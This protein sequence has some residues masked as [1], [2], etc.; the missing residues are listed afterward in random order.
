MDD[1]EL[2]I[3]NTAAA[4]TLLDSLGTMPNDQARRDAVSE[5]RRIYN[6]MAFALVRLQR[7]R[8]S[9]P[10]DN[11]VRAADRL[12]NDLQRCEPQYGINIVWIYEPAAD[13]NNSGAAGYLKNSNTDRTITVLPEAAR[14]LTNAATRETFIG[15]LENL[16]ARRLLERD[17]DAVRAVLGGVPFSSNR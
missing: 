6:E 4:F 11:A 9:L 10:E 16:G 5:A 7:M 3:D 2:C 8:N 14:A 17:Q 1:L 13:Y 15:L 12:L